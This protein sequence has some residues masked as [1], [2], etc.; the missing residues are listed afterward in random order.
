MI[1]LTG[2]TLGLALGT[3]WTTL[4]AYG[5]VIV[6]LA[7]R[8]IVRW[9][10]CD[11][12]TGGIALLSLALLPGVFYVLSFTRYLMITHGITNLPQ[13][14]LSFI[15]F[16][17]NLGGA[18]SELREWHW[19][20]W[21]YHITLTA[22]HIFYSPWWYWPLDFRPVVY[23]Y[24]DKGLGIDQTSGATLV[25]ESFNLGNP[26]IWWAATS[27]LV[28]IAIGL[29][30]L[31]RDYRSRRALEPSEAALRGAAGPVPQRLYLSIF[32]LVA[33]FAAWLPFS[34][35]PRGLFLYHMLGGVPAMV[36]ARAL[37][38]THPPPLRGR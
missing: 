11:G 28:G 9:T 12:A 33:F 37:A 22:P 25:A 18:W 17:F 27:S 35:V 31:I 32:I 38:V 26:M 14:A 36:L 4:A 7:F 23:Y 13:P 24:T 20:T 15:P 34:R 6:I 1:V 29:P 5:T 3:S 21:H 2:I 16:H 19:Q 8:L 30:A 10:R